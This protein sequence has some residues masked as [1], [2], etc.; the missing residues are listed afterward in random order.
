MANDLLRAGYEAQAE[1]RMWQ[2]FLV[3]Q[4]EGISFEDYKK[5]FKP[6]KAKSINKIA[7]LEA[8]K[9][10]EEFFNKGGA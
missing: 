3:E 7:A 1:E 4:P 9:G 6:K 10:A 2:R 8:A 5:R